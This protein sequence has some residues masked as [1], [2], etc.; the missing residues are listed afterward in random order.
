[1]IEM[2]KNYQF[3]KYYTIKSKFNIFY[4]RQIGFI[5]LYKKY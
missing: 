3:K 1:M 2:N 5:F 4:I